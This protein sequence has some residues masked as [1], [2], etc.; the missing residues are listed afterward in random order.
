MDKL[1]SV[2]ATVLN[3]APS[4]ISPQTSPENTASWDS[5]NAIV[6]ITEIEKAFSVKFSYEEAMRIKTFGDVVNVLKSKG[7]DPAS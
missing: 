5:M 2:F 7:I 6:L 3:V 4:Q 1:I